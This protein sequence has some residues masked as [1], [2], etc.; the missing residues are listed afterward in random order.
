MA[1]KKTIKKIS[2]R[3]D[4]LT[5]GE[6]IESY[7]E[8]RKEFG[9]PDEAKVSERAFRFWA[10]KGLFSPPYRG[11]FNRALYPKSTELDILVIRIFQVTYGLS[12]NQI[13]ELFEGFTVSYYEAVE[14]IKKSDSSLTRKEF[15]DLLSGNQP[16][17]ISL[18]RKIIKQHLPNYAGK[19]EYKSFLKDLADLY[20]KISEATYYSYLNK[21]GDELFHITIELIGKSEEGCP[22]DPIEWSRIQF[23]KGILSFIDGVKQQQYEPEKGLDM[24]MAMKPE[25]YKICKKMFSYSRELRLSKPTKNQK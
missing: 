1:D 21:T 25:A 16:N 4:L 3:E 2:E 11:K 8:F 23:V 10:A 12:I 15:E 18:A 7:E 14:N 17:K 20:K 22:T 19:E 6:L 24:V 13:K 9:Y 5:V